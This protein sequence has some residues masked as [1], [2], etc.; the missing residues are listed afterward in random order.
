MSEAEE[1]AAEE[2]AAAEESDGVMMAETLRG[3]IRDRLLRV[4]QDMAKPWAKMKEA[5]QKRLADGVEALADDIIMDAIRIVHAEGSPHMPMIVG[6]VAFGK[7]VSV[8]LMASRNDP[9]RHRLADLA[10]G[11]SVML[12]MQDANKFRGERAPAQTDPDQPDLEDDLDYAAAKKAAGETQEDGA[13]DAATSG[14]GKA[15]RPPA[16][17]G[18][19]SEPD[20]ARTKETSTDTT[21]ATI[22]HAAKVKRD[23]KERAAQET[24]ART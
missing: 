22:A 4:I 18:E 3:D 2:A 14:D 13:P 21:A 16:A 7:G 20:T 5:D 15:D 23:R 10:D 6:K 24:E 19:Q 17:V 9:E 11:A 12:V 8:A 1:A